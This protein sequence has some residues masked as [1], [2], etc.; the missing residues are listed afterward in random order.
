M[1]SSQSFLTEQTLLSARDAAAAM[2]PLTFPL[3]Q[4]IS[5]HSACDGRA[6]STT[7]RG[8]KTQS[9]NSPASRDKSTVL[10][11]SPRSDVIILAVRSVPPVGL[12]ITCANPMQSRHHTEYSQRSEKGGN[13]F[14]KVRYRGAALICPPEEITLYRVCMAVEPDPSKSL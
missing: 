12:K 11:E 8:S 10:T 6:I 13:P 2:A 5:P 4:D 9:E 3:T 1:N 7:S 14:R